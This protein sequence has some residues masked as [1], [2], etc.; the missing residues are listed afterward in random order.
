MKQGLRV[1]PANAK[2]GDFEEIGTTANVSQDGVYFVTKLDVYQKGMR[3]SVTVPYHSPLSPQNY[4]YHG[5]VARIDDL[6]NGQRGIAVR[7]VSS[8]K[9]QSPSA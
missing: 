4:E 6:G 1:R 3:L 8:A 7:F 2:I 9:K 5:H